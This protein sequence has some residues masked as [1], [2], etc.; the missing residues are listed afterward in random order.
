MPNSELRLFQFSTSPVRTVMVDGEPWFVAKDLCDIL[1]IGN[2]SQ[3][4][5]RILPAWK[6]IYSIDTLG[7]TQSMSGSE[8]G[9]TNVSTL[10]TRSEKGLSS[11]ETL[12]EIQSIQELESSAKGECK[13]PTLGRTQSIQRLEDLEKGT[14]NVGT[15]GGD[16]SMATAP[17]HALP[18]LPVRMKGSHTVTTLVRH[19]DEIDRCVR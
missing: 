4:V 10:G 19:M 5:G 16:Q 7:G 14:H 11:T 8:K 13:A 2:P 15:L 18:R 17:Y 3:A 12:G 6:G 9:T 1:E